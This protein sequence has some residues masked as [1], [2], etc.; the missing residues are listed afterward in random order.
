MK[1]DKN[2]EY[3]VLMIGNS[4]SY[5]NNMNGSDGIFYKIAESEGYNVTVTPIHSGGYYLHKFLDP[6]DPYG[7]Q[8]KEKLENNRYDVIVIQEQSSYPIREFTAFFGS[9]EKFKELADQNG[10]ELYLY[11]TWGYKDGCPKLEQF[12]PRSS[13]MGMKLRHEYTRAAENIGAGIA[14]VG[15]AFIDIGDKIELY[16]PDQ[17]HPSLLGSTL[18]AYTIF[19]SVFG[20]DPNEFKY[21]GDLDEETAALLKSAASRAILK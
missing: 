5:Y 20:T 14:E 19:G 16:E 15:T 11:A 12:G 4:F 3:N 10:A 17:Q 21:T 18:A 8:V 6:N 13:D 2:R 9:C 7:A 1:R